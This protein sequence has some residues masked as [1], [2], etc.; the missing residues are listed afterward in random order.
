[1]HRSSHASRGGHCTRRRKSS[2]PRRTKWRQRARAENDT[3][4]HAIIDASHPRHTQAFKESHGSHVCDELKALEAAISKDEATEEIGAKMYEL[5]CTSL[6]DYDRDEADENKLVP[7][8][9]KGEV[10]PKDAPGLVEVMT[11]LYV[12]G[13]R[14]IPS[15]FIEVDRCKEIVEERLA[16]RVG[17]TGEQLDDWLDVPDMGV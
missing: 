2:R 7:S 9:S 6:L 16:K 4:L 15:G 17:M 10:I 13:I 1:L 14:M 11:N 5:L 8:A 12:Y 3:C